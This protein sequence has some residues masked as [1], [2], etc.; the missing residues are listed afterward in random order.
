MSSTA[1]KTSWSDHL[2]AIDKVADI[3][4]NQEKSALLPII[5]ASWERS[6]LSGLSMDRAPST[7]PHASTAQLAMLMHARQQLVAY[8]CPEMRRLGQRMPGFNGILMLADAS[9]IVLCSMGDDSFAETAS[10]VALRAGANWNERWRGTNAIGTVIA[11]GMPVRI[12]GMEHYM[13]SNGFLTCAAAP[14]LDAQGH[15]TGVLN[16]SNRQ[17]SLSAN[18]LNQVSESAARIEMGIFMSSFAREKILSLRK[19]TQD[20]RRPL[21]G[22]MALS[23]NGVIVGANATAKR[24]TGL[25]E[26]E[27]GKTRVED[28]LDAFGPFLL[29][30]R[31]PAEGEFQAS[32]HRGNTGVLSS[33]STK[34][35]EGANTL[36]QARWATST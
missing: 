22:L 9:G 6:L 5:Q 1:L 13:S 18:T 24:L 3:A 14:V 15:L 25:A 28:L 27:L 32:F 21:E 31:R 4:A 7:V 23:E 12:D 35:T 36:V 8:A 26:Y 30:K 20:Q 2:S 34:V 10:R 29:P 11:T 17:G 16:A 19:H 33:R